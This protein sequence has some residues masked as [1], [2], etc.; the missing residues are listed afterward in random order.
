MS[1]SAGLGFGSKTVS[2]IQKTNTTTV[3]MKKPSHERKPYE[4][5]L[6]KNLKAGAGMSSKTINQSSIA[7][8]ATT[9]EQ[10]AL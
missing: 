3:G 9:I 8:S 10:K 1:A 2:K 7:Q 6:T 5:F 4:S